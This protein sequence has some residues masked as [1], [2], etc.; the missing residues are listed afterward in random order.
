MKPHDTFDQTAH[1]ERKPPPGSRMV[2]LRISLLVAIAFIICGA[3]MFRLISRYAVNVFFADQW[4]FNN[5]TL[6]ERHSLWQMFRWQHG[7]HRQG[8]GALFEKM[9]DPLFGWNSRTESFVIGGVIVAAAIC[10]LW[11]KKRL[12]GKIS[13]FDV[14]IP[15]IL[16]TT[17]QWQT[18]F[19]TQNF[20][21]GPFPL[22]LLL[23]YCLSWS[24][25]TQGARYPLVLFINFV[26][27]YTGFGIFL[28]VLTPILLIVDYSAGTPENRLS[29][30]YFTTAIIVAVG[31]LVSFFAGYRFQSAVSCFSLPPQSPTSYAQFVALMFANFF[32]VKRLTLATELVGFM[33]LAAV[34]ISLIASLWLLFRNKRFNVV[35][36]DRNRALIVVSLTAFTLL[37]CFNTAYGRLCEGLQAA[38]IS[39]YVIYLE[40]AVLGFYFFLLSF[41]QSMVRKFL[42]SGFLIAVVAGSLY[43]DRGGMDFAWN[44]KQHWKTCY[45]QTEDIEGCDRVAGFPI[46]PNPQRSHLKEKLE[47]LKRTHQNL[48]LDEKTQ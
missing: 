20:A 24:S 19:M 4:D 18:L 46:Y 2:K 32:A 12:Y 6:F 35:R 17:A 41:R 10:A 36:D 39:R 7:P 44:V 28:G 11:L 26:T 47:Y 34:L 25:K 40:P 43:R 5:A 13:V 1:R 37:F 23:L 29:R 33:V 22:L 30:G 21:H 31:S 14:A 3:R 27:I 16:F 9:V 15:A 42:L 45:L 8:V 48:Y 38:S